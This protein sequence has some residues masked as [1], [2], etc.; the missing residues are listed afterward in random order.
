MALGHKSAELKLFC[1]M[2]T[3]LTSQHLLSNYPYQPW[4][5]IACKS[6]STIWLQ[7]DTY[8]LNVLNVGDHY[9]EVEQ[10][11]D[12]APIVK[13]EVLGHKCFLQV[14]WYCKELLAFSLRSCGYKS[15]WHVAIAA[16][17]SITS[18]FRS[19]QLLRAWLRSLH[20]LHIVRQPSVHDWSG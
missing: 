16:G 1:A 2:T 18:S 5:S 17:I 19:L 14:E 11:R 4:T 12:I 9:S 7:H 6:S 10:T 3:V 8:V 20:S 13:V 15:G